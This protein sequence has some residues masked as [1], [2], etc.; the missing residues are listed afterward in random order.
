MFSD[1]KLYTTLGVDKSASEADIK[2]AYKKLALKY[3][4]D[5]NKDPKAEST[6]KEISK[7][8]N[9]LGDSDKR[10]NYDMFGLDGVNAG[11]F[12]GD[13]GK[14][15]FDVFG[16]IFGSH[17]FG[18]RT[19]RNTTKVG[20]NVVK[21]IEIGLEDFFLET[22]IKVGLSRMVACETCDGKGCKDPMDIVTCAICDGSGMFVKVQQFG[23]GMISQSTQ[24]CS[25]CLGKGKIVNPDK[26]CFSCDGSKRTKKKVNVN[27]K[28]SKTNKSDDKIVFDHMADYDPDVDIQG[29]L[30][31]I[32]KELPNSNFIRLEND[33]VY[34]KTIS[35]IEALC[36]M[37][38]SIPH[39]D[40]RMLFCKTSDVIQPNSFMKIDDEGMGGALYIKFNVVFPQ[41]L[42]D[43]RKMY[44]KKLINQPDLN[45]TDEA[46]NTSNRHFKFLNT[47]TEAESNSIE[48]RI[49]SNDRRSRKKRT[50]QTHTVED[51]A[52]GCTTQ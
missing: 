45:C 51:E 16:D 14:N 47:I 20:A 18:G 32:L 17:S 34:I 4:P 9:V 37:E 27:F 3:H 29:N 39:L 41:K 25:K 8:Y 6:F 11:G 7:A 28:L 49:Q 10:K 15:P 23:P 30:I 38:L 21:E 50:R 26:L 5:R 48:K 12:A 52:P 22:D 40:N 13:A 46:K 2:K 43:E 35:L 1:T 44:I 42:S 36:G 24:M 33:L 19:S 31:I